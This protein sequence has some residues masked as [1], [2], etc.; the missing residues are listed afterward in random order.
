MKEWTECVSVGAVVRSCRSIQACQISF[1]VIVCPSRL[2]RFLA[3]DR[4]RPRVA[5]VHVFAA[6]LPLPSLLS[7]CRGF[8]G[9]K[10]PSHESAGIK[11]YKETKPNRSSAAPAL[12]LLSVAFPSSLFVC[13][14]V[15][16]RGPC[17]LNNRIR[18]AFSSSLSCHRLWF[19]V[20]GGFDLFYT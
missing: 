10:G 3:D 16:V 2:G 8:K 18:S 12:S 13:M 7:R 14:C 1:V 11:W 20:D 15:R 6:L 5:A 9:S 17:C 4:R 19:K